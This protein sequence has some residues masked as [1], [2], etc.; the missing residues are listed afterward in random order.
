MTVID[1][2]D[3]DT[4]VRDTDR[5][6]LP[7]I[8]QIYAHHVLTGL[9][10]FEEN[11]PD[12]AEMARRWQAIASAG[13]PYLTGTIGGTV[14]GF[15]YAGPYRT[16][17]AY[18]FTVEDSIYL[19]P[20]FTR[21]GLGGALLTVLVER[22]TALGYRQMIAVIGDSANEGSIALHRRLGFTRA[23]TLTDVGHK[24]GR[25]VDSVLMQRALIPGG[26]P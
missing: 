7:A 19:N 3:E 5:T 15:A 9:G 24:F 18:R 12:E 1:R 25:P 21:R 14:A 13:L 8:T 22:C 11:P 17:S 2:A 16:R 26:K 4:I 10:T 20:K 23:G 6:D